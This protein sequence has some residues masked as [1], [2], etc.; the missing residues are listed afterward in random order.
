MN[1][2][3]VIIGALL[4]AY[5]KVAAGTLL[6]PY[7]TATAQVVLL[8]PLGMWLG[9]VLWLRSLCDYELPQRYRVV[10]STEVRR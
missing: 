6:Q 3:L 1:K 9:C 5:L 8:L 10:G 7:D 4:V 2:R